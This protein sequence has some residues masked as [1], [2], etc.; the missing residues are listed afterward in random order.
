MPYS[1]IVD[2]EAITLKGFDVPLEA[3][4]LQVDCCTLETIRGRTYRIKQPDTPAQLALKYGLNPVRVWQTC[5]VLWRKLG[6]TVL[7][8]C[9]WDWSEVSALL[10]DMCRGACAVY[11]KG[12]RLEKRMLDFHGILDLA[13]F[14]A[15][16]YPHAEHD[17]LDECV[18]F[19]KF[20]PL[21]SCQE[22]GTFKS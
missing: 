6:L 22:H 7:R 9:G 18:F 12:P 15:E 5:N 17:P 3:A 11:A 8:P 14:G 20:I 10:R 16:K 21:N 4:Y 2:I 1:I 13:D 19:K